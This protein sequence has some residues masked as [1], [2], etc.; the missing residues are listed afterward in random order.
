MY[1]KEKTDFRER[2]RRETLRG[3]T[4]FFHENIEMYIFR[5]AKAY[6]TTRIFAHWLIVYLFA[7]KCKRLN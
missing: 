5:Q 6:T 1:P 2:V 4:T 3:S 7:T